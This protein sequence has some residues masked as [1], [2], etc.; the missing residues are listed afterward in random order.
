MSIAGTLR[1]HLE[2]TGLEVYYG[3]FA[4]APGHGASHAWG[5]N[6][7]PEVGSSW[8]TSLEEAKA[9]AKTHK[10]EPGHT[11]MFVVKLVG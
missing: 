1:Y 4:G 7:H 5:C 2:P 11:G 8:C 3:E 10:A 9:A 6:R